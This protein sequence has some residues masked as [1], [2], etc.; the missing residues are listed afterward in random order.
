MESVRRAGVTR[1]A[2]IL[3][4][5]CGSGHLIHDLWYFGFRKAE[6]GGSVPRARS[7]L[8]GRTNLYKKELSEMPK[9]YDLI[10][11]AS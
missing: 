4:V 7:R 10:M 9:G 1:E 5:G 3:D 11:R 8:S 6:G 2:R